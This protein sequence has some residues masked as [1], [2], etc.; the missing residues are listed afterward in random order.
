VP[1]PLW[2]GAIS[3]VG[4]P[5]E[6]GVVFVR[7]ELEPEAVLEVGWLGGG[8]LAEEIV[9]AARI[10]PDE[11]DE[12]WVTG[13]D[14]RVV[15][16]GALAFAFDACFADLRTRERELLADERFPAATVPVCPATCV[17]VPPGKPCTTTTVAATPSA[18][19]SAPTIAHVSDSRRR[20]SEGASHRRA[21]RVNPSSAAQ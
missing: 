12:R 9:C 8:E 19:A 13:W 14:R 10:A 3:G 2:R 7:R 11:D 6:L 18:P 15:A 5:L 20:G 1:D 4:P 16:R 17:G 21:A